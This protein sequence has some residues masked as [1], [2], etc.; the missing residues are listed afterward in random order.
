MRIIITGATGLV[1]RALARELLS[2]GHEVEAWTRSPDV[3]GPRLPPGC[4]VVGWH[5]ER[6]DPRSIAGADAVLHLAGENVAAGRWTKARKN[7]LHS[8]R[9]DVTEALVRA[10]ADLPDSE[11]PASLITA[12]AIGFYGDRGEE[13]LSEEVT[14][15]AGFMPDLCHDWERAAEAAE[16]SGVRVAMLR[17]GIVLIAGC[18]RLFFI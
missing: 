10:I 6:I 14:P 16:S 13:R 2:R 9:V 18:P 15:G 7:A 17:I 4:T 11:R 8:S 1:G 5:P 3:S 12:S